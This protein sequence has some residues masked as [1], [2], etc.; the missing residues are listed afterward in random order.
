MRAQAASSDSVSCAATVGGVAAGGNGTLVLLPSTLFLRGGRSTGQ[1][2]PEVEEQHVQVGA[3]RL[4]RRHIPRLANQVG[5]LRS[6]LQPAMTRIAPDPR[7]RTRVST[8]GSSDSGSTEIPCNRSRPPSVRRIDGH[9]LLEP[10]AAV[11]AVQSQLRRGLILQPIHGRGRMHQRGLPSPWMI[12][13]GPNQDVSAGPVAVEGTGEQ[14]Q[15]FTTSKSRL[16]D[17]PPP[18][19]SKCWLARGLRSNRVSTPPHPISRCRGR[20]SDRRGRKRSS[21][22]HPG[23]VWARRSCS[24]RYSIATRRTARN[25]RKAIVPE[26]LA[27]PAYCSEASSDT[28]R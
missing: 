5:V 1:E 18:T 11:V 22:R 17:P 12:K 21:R 16:T 27:P 14:T 2:V 8:A 7:A 25:R 10:G 15:V 20:F 23:V 9:V 4:T 24:S 26:P 13:S 6:P 28:P 3:T 19:A